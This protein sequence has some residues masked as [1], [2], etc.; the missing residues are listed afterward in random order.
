MKNVGDLVIWACFGL[1]LCHVSVVIRCENDG[2][3]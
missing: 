2:L 1:C 3:A